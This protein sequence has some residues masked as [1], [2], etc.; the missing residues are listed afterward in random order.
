MGTRW[1]EIVEIIDQWP[2]ARRDDAVQ[3]LAALIEQGDGV[4]Q[5]SAD[6]RRAI[7]LS[8]EQMRNGEFATDEEVAAVRRKHGL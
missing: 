3:I 2:E 1:K 5:L 4:Y 8:R 7:D 6:E